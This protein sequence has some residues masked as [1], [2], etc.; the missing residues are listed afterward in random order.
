[1]S[2][3]QSIRRAVALDPEIARLVD[4]GRW[5]DVIQRLE[6]LIERATSSERA[7]LL[8]ELGDLYGCRFSNQTRAAKAYERALEQVPGDI[9]ILERLVP[10]CERRRAWRRLAEILEQIAEAIDD[11]DRR[12]TLVG[13]ATMIRATRLGVVDDVLVELSHPAGEQVR[14]ATWIETPPKPRVRPVAAW[15][16]KWGCELPLKVVPWKYRNGWVARWLV[17]ARVVRNPWG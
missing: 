17:R 16:V 15:S 7:D 4:L 6:D 9:N 5:S 11:D 12:I 3:S 8:V 14:L 1:M 13:K 2:A 10:I